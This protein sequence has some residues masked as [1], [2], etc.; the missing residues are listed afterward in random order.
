MVDH[1]KP[2]KELLTTFFV[3]FGSAVKSAEL[4]SL[5]E[6]GE[7]GGS[8]LMA[9]M[10]IAPRDRAIVKLECLRLLVALRLDSAKQRIISEFIDTYLELTGEEMEQYVRAR[11]KLPEPEQEAIMER[12]TSWSKA[13]RHQEALLLVSKWLNRRFGTVDDTMLERLESLAT[14]ELEEFSTELLDSRNIAD[15]EHWLKSRGTVHN[16]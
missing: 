13:G 6:T 9:K 11:G 2:F 7:P 1:D 8:A 4:A 12:E 3:E 15:L 16:E 14:E 5:C 10:S